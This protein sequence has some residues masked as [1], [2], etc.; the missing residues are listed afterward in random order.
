[1]QPN[2]WMR[3]LIDPQPLRQENGN[4]IIALSEDV[5]DH[6]LVRG[7]LLVEL[8]PYFA[9]RVG[10][11]PAASALPGSTFSSGFGAV[12]DTAIDPITGQEFTIYGLCLHWEAPIGDED[13]NDGAAWMLYGYDVASGRPFDIRGHRRPT[14]Q[15]DSFM[16][17]KHGDDLI[18]SGLLEHAHTSTGPL[19]YF[20]GHWTYP[21][22]AELGA[23]LEYKCLFN[24]LFDQPSGIQDQESY[25]LST[26]SIEPLTK[27]YE[28][29]PRLAV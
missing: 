12:Y 1:M 27:F 20:C 25:I 6:L 26:A 3:S 21:R 9:P 14:S 23:I 10:A 17:S 15:T 29:M 8:S 18:R 11:S 24:L 22:A 4:V 16:Y 2:L 7:D 28:W 5:E 19:P 13:Q